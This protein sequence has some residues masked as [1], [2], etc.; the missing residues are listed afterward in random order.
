MRNVFRTIRPVGLTD[1][2]MAPSLNA[3]NDRMLF[4]QKRPVKTINIHLIEKLIF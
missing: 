4:G 1:Y 2:L 3:R